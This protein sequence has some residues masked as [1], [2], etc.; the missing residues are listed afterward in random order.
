MIAVIKTHNMLM[1]S[2]KNSIYRSLL[3]PVVF[4]LLFTTVNGQKDEHQRNLSFIKQQ[5]TAFNSIVL[6]N[7]EQGTIPIKDLEQ[8]IASVNVNVATAPRFDSLLNKYTVV[9]SFSLPEKNSDSSINSLNDDLKFYNTVIV[10]INAA[11]LNDRNILN[12]IYD[13]QRSKQLFLVVYGKPASLKY[14][15]LIIQPIIWSVENNT[16]AADIAAQII[17]GGVSSIGK[18]R[19][20]YSGQ[21]RKN[22]GYVTAAIRLTYSV[23]E[24]TGINI[25]DLNL[26]ID[27]IATEAITKHAIP[28][29]VIMI[30]KDGRV[31]FNKAYGYQTY[32]STEKMKVADIFDMASVTKVSATTMATMRL[33]EQQKINLDSSFGYY[34]PSARNTNK[35]NIK[36]RALLLHQSG[37]QPGVILPLTP[38]DISTDSSTAFPL[39]AGDKTFI[40]AGYFKE[41]MWPLMLGVRLDSVVKYAYSDLSMTYMKE[42]VERQSLQ[43]LDE[44]A[45]TQFYNP[46]GMQSAGF[47]PLNRFE[48]NRIVPTEQENIFRKIMLRGYVHD[49]MAARYGGVSGNAGL[50]ANA[51]DLAILYQMILNGG[52]YG[53]VK[54]F[55]PETIDLFT[56]SQSH[57]SRRGLGFDRKD[58]DSTKNYPSLLASPGTYGHTGFTGTSF[59]IDPTYKL[60]FIFLSNRVY[61]KVNNDLFTLNIQPRILDA[62]YKAINK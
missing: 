56:S 16:A 3:T 58:P 13:I 8:K 57:I 17:F 18:L 35:S 54:Y 11:D 30:V 37:I 24:E 47:N 10:Q 51:N 53:D 59:W 49:P 39:K 9:T 22:A 45:A 14:A 34:I 44:Y 2:G 27:S 38:I 23:P 60:I 19:R 62:I 31:I 40:R 20:T 36:I 43:R 15:D 61:P 6:L 29:A 50:F 32:D 46:L 12:L 1:L 33:Y 25:T 7:N 55:N 26:P 52:T 4:V 42:V 28:G 5:K 21:Y 41:V 48:I